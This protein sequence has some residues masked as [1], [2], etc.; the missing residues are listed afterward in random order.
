V[1]LTEQWARLCLEEKRDDP[2]ALFGIVQGGIY[3]DL[4]EL[5]ARGV[6]RLGFDGYAMGGLAI[7]EDTSTREEIVRLT[8]EFLPDEKPTYL[9]GVGTP[10]DIIEAV[11]MGLDMFD[12]VLPTRGARNGMLYTATGKLIIKNSRYADDESPIEDGCKCYTCTHYSRAYLRHLYLS[13]EILASTL[14]TI[15]NLSYYS[16]LL[17]EIRQAIKENRLAEFSRDFYA[18]RVENQDQDKAESL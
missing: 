2:Q 9:M 14:N 18:Q 3:P 6:V 15:H 1:R 12:C 17:S 11:K 13:R 8:R 7:G 5:S 4:R 10:E 16:R